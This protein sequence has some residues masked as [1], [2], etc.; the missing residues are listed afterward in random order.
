MITPVTP[1]LLRADCVPCYRVRSHIQLIGLGPNISVCIRQ[2]GLNGNRLALVIIC[3]LNRIC[4]MQSTAQLTIRILNIRS[5][6]LHALNTGNGITAVTNRITSLFFAG[7]RAVG[8]QGTTIH[9]RLTLTGS[10]TVSINYRVI[11]NHTGHS[12][13][14]VHNRNIISIPSC[15][16]HSVTYC[17]GSNGNIITVNGA[18]AV[19]L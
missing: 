17:V 6:I 12:Q 7:L 11:L 2:I 5:R 3:I 1:H 19:C 14:A 4:N 9:I 8:N 13:V 15:L 16:H 18:A 10:V